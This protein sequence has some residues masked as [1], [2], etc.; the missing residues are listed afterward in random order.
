MLLN[1]TYDK[2]NDWYLKEWLPKFERSELAVWKIDIFNFL[3]DW[4]SNK[5]KF[6]VKTSGTTGPSKI[7]LIPR[8]AFIISAQLT[9]STFNLEK[10]NTL[11][12]CLPMRFVAGKMMLVRA[13]VGRMKLVLTQPTVN[14]VDDL[15]YPITFAAFTPHQLHAIL[16][17][18]SDKLRLIEMAIIGGS[19]V[20][21]E[22]QNQLS[23][24]K[25]RFFETFGMS[26]TLT[27][28]AI[29]ELNGPNRS[30]YFKVLKG[31]N[32]RVDENEQLIIEADH[33]VKSPLVT[34]DIVEI[35]NSDSFKWLSRVDDVINSGGVKLYPAIIE[36]KLSSVIEQEFIIGKRND[37]NL[38]ESVTL[39]IEGEPFNKD[40]LEGLKIEFTKML[41][42]FEIPKIIIFLPEFERNENGKIIRSKIG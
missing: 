5:D 36:Q 37:K 25:T 24:L 3:N 15:Q 40:K 8:E 39:F 6:E 23:D 12:M 29:K 41:S 7:E 42:K 14:P 35:I 4:F 16:E 38:G 22:L 30:D 17:N 18:N 28:I 20:K 19:P 27:H 26:E 1:F 34:S 31:F 10:G 21:S 2:S 11:L 32:I 13:I 33:L 9:I